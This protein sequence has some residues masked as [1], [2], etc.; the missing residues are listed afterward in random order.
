MLKFDLPWL[1]IGVLGVA[2][3][4]L[5]FVWYSFLFVKPWVK[6]LKITPEAMRS[7]EARRQMP[8]LMGAAALTA[9]TLSFG[10]QVLVA[11]LGATDALSGAIIGI[12]I[13]IVIVGAHASGSLF[14][15]RPYMVYGIAVLHAV[16]VLTLDCASLAAWH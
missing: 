10:S 1:H 12:F 11:S 6:A 9:F 7:A 4:F 3:F 16:A 5:G 13:A 15:R 8:I 2:N 14:E